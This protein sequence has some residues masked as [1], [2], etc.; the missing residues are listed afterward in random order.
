MSVTILNMRHSKSLKT[1]I[2][3]L[4]NPEYIYVVIL[5]K[6]ICFVYVCSYI[7]KLPRV[8]VLSLAD[9][10]RNSDLVV[11]VVSLRYRYERKH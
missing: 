6:T 2:C 11:R 4:C 8:T 3:S 7:T 10:E 5:Y 9:H 1:H